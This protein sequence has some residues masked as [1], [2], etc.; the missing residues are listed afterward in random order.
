MSHNVKLAAVFDAL[1]DHLDAIEAEKT[2]SAAAVRRGKIDELA[3]KY[4]TATGEELP[5]EIRAKLA[6]SDETVVAL[7]R[8]MAEKQASAIEP[9]GGP[10]NRSDEQPVTMTKKEAADAAHERF[11]NWLT[12]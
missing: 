1:A 7:L 12:S 6:D 2:S 9:L 8:G 10:S 3:S 5:A 11:G 4:A